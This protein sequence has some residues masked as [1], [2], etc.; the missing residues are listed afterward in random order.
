MGS[1][2]ADKGTLQYFVYVVHFC[3]CAQVCA[4]AGMYTYKYAYFM[5][6]SSVDSLLTMKTTIVSSCSSVLCRYSTTLVIQ[7]PLSMG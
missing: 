7:T 4:Y 6:L 2:F 1:I 3:R 5:G